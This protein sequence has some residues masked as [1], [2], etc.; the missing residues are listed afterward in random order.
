MFNHQ[1]LYD[2]P[3]GPPAW[4]VNKF[5]VHDGEKKKWNW[6]RRIAHLCVFWRCPYCSWD[7]SNRGGVATDKHAS[8]AEASLRATGEWEQIKKREAEEW[9]RKYWHCQQPDV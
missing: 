2:N 1:H 8:K 3:S 4:F 9:L 5:Y 6:L 7:Y